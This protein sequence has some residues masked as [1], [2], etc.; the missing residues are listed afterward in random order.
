[1]TVRHHLVHLP[2]STSRKVQTLQDIY[3]HTNKFDVIIEDH[4]F[5]AK[6]AFSIFKYPLNHI[7]CYLIIH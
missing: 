1:M 4:K 3:A 6:F 5:E 2:K 7:K